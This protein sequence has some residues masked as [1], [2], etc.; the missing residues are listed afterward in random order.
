M[1]K[2]NGQ[3]AIAG[4]GA[5][6]CRYDEFLTLMEADESLFDFMGFSREEFEKEFGNHVLEAIYEGDRE[7]ILEEIKRQLSKGKVFMYENRLKV[8]GG[9]NRWVWVSAELKQDDTDGNWFHCTF[10]DISC[11]KEAQERLEMSE[12]RYEIILSHMQD[13]IFELDCTTYDIYYSP[14]FEKKFGYQIPVKGFPDSMFATDIVYEEDKAPLRKRFQAMLK[15]SGEMECEYRLK[16]IDGTYIWVDVHATAL[17]DEEGRLLKILGIISDIDQRKQEI[18]KAKRAATSDPL[19]GLL[20]RRECAAQIEQYMR[21][22]QEPAAFLLIDVDNFKQINDTYGHL[23]GDS[24][25]NQAAG[26]LKAIFRRN[27][28]VGRIGGDE[29]VVFMTNLSQRGVI[30]SKT[31]DIQHIFQ[32]FAVGDMPCGIGCSIGVSFYP[33][34]GNDFRSLFSKADVAMYQAKK[35][36][37]GGYCVYGNRVVSE[38]DTDPIQPSREM[39]KNLHDYILEYTL[40]IFI[41]NTQNHCAV[42][43]LLNL[44]GRVF[45]A[46]RI[47]IF[48]KM[49]TMKLTNTY[50]WTS[51]E[52]ASDGIKPPDIRRFPMEETITFYNDTGKLKDLEMRQ[53]FAA[54]STKAAAVFCMKDMEEILTAVVYEDCHD[55][56][57]SSDEER[58]SILMI[59]RLIHLFLLKEKAAGERNTIK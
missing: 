11:E 49:N 28:I 47:Y 13:I 34:H 10:H 25:L 21:E 23:Y 3:K 24:V 33:G 9:I 46:D 7:I 26:S 27:D 40:N 53:W 4:G 15:G 17:R 22:N 31:A 18:L 35:K 29:F 12:K 16:K 55:T 1:E 8:K 14:S 59:S 48:Q 2:G 30:A 37:K 50:G 20:N 32:S 54:R 43:K 58:Y 51:D 5:F 57:P 42:P 38:D 6:N 41:E 39:Q 44:L 56:R 19:T 52:G 45:S 36:G